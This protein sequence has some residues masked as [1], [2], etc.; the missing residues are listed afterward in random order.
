M[1]RR[2]NRKTDDV[3]I[4]ELN[5]VGLSLAGIG[6]RMGVH[7]TTIKHRLNNMGIEPFD[8]RRSFM[9]DIFDSLTLQQQRWLISQLG[10]DYS[11]K[12]YLRQL[13]LREFL[14]ERTRDKA[15]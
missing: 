6:K 10:P 7:H 2:Y 15:G 13:I 9:E 11:I 1:A 3:L 4:T 12:S 14:M 8:T 5:S